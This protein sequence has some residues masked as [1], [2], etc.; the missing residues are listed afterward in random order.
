MIP[1]QSYWIDDTDSELLDYQDLKLSDG[2]VLA[3]A[4]KVVAHCDKL[5]II[6]VWSTDSWACERTFEGHDGIV[7]CLV[8]R[9]TSR[10]T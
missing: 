4:V 1:T 8:C 10:S 6:K 9:A 7:M 3:M 2:E 5:R